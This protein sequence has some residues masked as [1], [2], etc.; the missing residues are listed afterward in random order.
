MNA[1]D[2][3]PTY[4]REELQHFRDLCGTRAFWDGSQE[5]R[6]AAFKGITVL[7][8]ASPGLTEAEVDG[9]RLALDNYNRR[10]R[11]MLDRLFRTLAE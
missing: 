10:E 8:L 4:F 11:F 2:V 7:Y 9:Y 6:D 5:A 3:S 1:A